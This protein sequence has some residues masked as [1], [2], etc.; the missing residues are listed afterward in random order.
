[1]QKIRLALKG[2]NRRREER[3]REFVAKNTGWGAASVAAAPKQPNLSQPE[4]EIDLEG[5]TT[6]YLDDS[7]RIAYYLDMAT[8]EVVEVRDGAGPAEPR[9]RRV[10]ARSDESEAEDR[11]LFAMEHETLAGSAG[12]RDA[13]RRAIAA[14]RSLERAWYSFK[15]DRAIAAVRQWLA[16]VGF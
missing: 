2:W 8:G 12:S 9:F 1:M 5:L 4:F 6:A 15:N 14:D 11:R 16:Q 10:P 13:F 3:D 7:G